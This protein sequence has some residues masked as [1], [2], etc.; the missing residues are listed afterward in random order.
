MA[1]WWEEEMADA[2]QQ[3]SQDPSM[4]L[5]IA[6]MPGSMVKPEIDP[7]LAGLLQTAKEATAREEKS[8]FME[9][10]KSFGSFASQAIDL[11]GSSLFGEKLWGGFRSTAEFLWTP[12]D[13]L[14]SS[15]YWMY[16]EV[17]S[18]PLTMAFLQASKVGV[19]G[20]FS[21]LT[22]TEEWGDAYK[23]AENI[24]PGQ[25]AANY[26]A[27]VGQAM[28]EQGVQGLGDAIGFAARN[29]LPGMGLSDDQ[30]RRGERLL[31]DTEY[32]RNKVG[33]KY[34]VGTGAA[35]FTIAVG[36]DPVY[37]IIKGVSKGVKY[38]R[39][40]EVAK[41]GMEP[42]K[43]QRSA[44]DAARSAQ[45]NEFYDFAADN[46]GK[47]MNIAAHPI[48]GKGRR[49]NTFAEAYSSVYANATRDEMP[50]ILRF[51]AGDPKAL[52]EIGRRNQALGLQLSRM[53][54]SR[55]FL[56]SGK[57]DEGVLAFMVSEEAAGRVAP[58]LPKVMGPGIGGTSP[59]SGMLNELIEPPYP[60]P[61]QPG[62]RQS[63]WDAT[64]GHLAAKGKALR[65][66]AGEVLTA[67]QGVLPTL[68]GTKGL[69][70]KDIKVAE[71]WR[72][73]KL[74]AVN[75]ELEALTKQQGVYQTLL[76][77]NF[78]KAI[79]D[80][81]PGSSN[82][83][84]AHRSL[85]RMGTYGGDV[86]KMGLKAVDRLSAGRGNVIKQQGGITSRVVRSGFYS[87][88]VRVFQTFGETL[89][90]TMINHTANDA[91]E[92]VLAM[93]KQVRGLDPALRVEM[94]NN[95]LSA[96]D[97]VARSRQLKTIHEAIIH[98]YG[99]ARGI[100]P[101]VSRIIA[102]M[103][104]NGMSATLN[105]LIG[106]TP[107]QQRFTAA[108][109]DETARF[110]DMVE[111]GE[112]LVV[113]PLAK[114]QLSQG[115][116]LLPVRDLER[117]IDR[118]AG[119]L[120]SFKQGMGNA[121]DFVIGSADGLSKVWKAATLLR[122]AY[123]VRS[124]SEEMAASVV[125]FGLLTRLGH[126]GE[127]GKHF[128]QNRG[129]QIQAFRGQASYIPTT[130]KGAA[131][132]LSRIAID[133]EEA[134][135][136]AAKYPELKAEKIK[137]PKQWAIVAERLQYETDRLSKM[138]T[139]LKNIYK[140]DAPARESTLDR[141]VGTADEL[142]A[143][144]ASSQAIVKEFSQYAEVLLRESTDATGKRLAEDMLEY[145]GVAFGEAFSP[146]WENPIAR[147]QITSAKAVDFLFSRGESIDLGRFIKTGDWQVVK[148]G[149]PNH[150][151]AWLNALNN[152]FRQDALFR[153]VAS[154]Q[155]MTAARKFLYSAEGK[156]HLRDLGPWADDID[157]LLNSIR[158]TLDQY[159]PR[160]TGLQSKLASGEH[161][162][163]AELRA[164]MQTEDFPMVHGEEL[165]A[166]ARVTARKSVSAQFDE[167]IRNGYMRL[168][169]I[170]S[171][172]L[173]RHP[174]F[175]ESYKIRMK[176]LIDNHI[177][178]RRE[179]GADESISTKELNTMYETATAKAKKDISQVVYDPSRTT[180]TEA[181]RFVAPFLSAHGDSLQRWAGLV[182]EK[183][184]FL[185]RVAQIY[186]APVAAN[187]ITDD[188]G[189]AVGQDGYATIELKV[190][191]P[192][193]GKTT[194]TKERKKVPLSERV[195][196]LRLPWDT[197]NK[198]RILGKVPF[199]GTRIKLQAMNTILPGDP[200]FHPGTGPLTQVPASAIAKL[201]PQTGEFLQWAKVIPYG[202]SG[203]WHE[204]FTPK[205]MKA[206]W[207]AFNTEDPDNEKYQQ[208]YLDVFNRH[209]AE[210]YEGKR[211]NIDLKK[212][213]QQAKQFMYLQAF[214]AWASPAQ[215]KDTPLT[216]TPY[217]FYVDQYR[218]M[219]AADPKNGAAQFQATHGSDYAHFAASLTKSIGVAPSISAMTTAE[220]HREMIERYPE[221]ASWIVGDVYNQ[222]SFS[223]S[224]YR[225]QMETMMG[226]K[227]MREKGSALD[228]IRS[229]E[230]AQGWQMYMQ[231]KGKMDAAL[232]SQGFRSYQDAGAEHLNALRQQAVDQ[233]SLMF[234]EWGKERG[235]VD[236]Q[237]TSNLIKFFTQAVQDPRLRSDPMRQDVPAMAQYLMIRQQFK[238]E[239]NAR[240]AKS[241]QFDVAGNPTG[242][243]ADLGY[244]WRVT[245]M[246]LVNSNT[247]FQDVFNRYLENDDLS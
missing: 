36:L 153:A 185:G 120:Q 173:V 186:N 203:E 21:Y 19:T 127:G 240:G 6:T 64:Y 168:S 107:N 175:N 150:M 87:T 184:E 217:Q 119:R 65:G 26:G 125:K 76:G 68:F 109:G 211:E 62:P 110:A 75:A 56:D 130:G 239:L 81:S 90:D 230:I 102:G 187:L 219:V 122:P 83:F 97:K 54:E 214:E 139:Q 85:Y 210:V 171:D 162:T 224:V 37:P 190:T 86:E 183:P 147:D 200:W 177:A 223:S 226:G 100:D 74:E 38:A 91:G 201:S 199:Y 40:I 7:K 98:H 180:A 61:T 166:L 18:Q 154:D 198:S 158:N 112:G 35:D 104:D 50:L 5:Q 69:R 39:N 244:S 45:V 82:L 20:D 220:E 29:P 48:W 135:A 197:R 3:M 169:G 188:Q 247:Q 167:L 189:N 208:A 142:E 194:T 106:K 115:E 41:P 52:V 159:V 207:D 55:A 113:A 246:G 118:H 156:A 111:D 27:T 114:T 144:I 80:F 145:R 34:T 53:N 60:R 15:A 10:L 66:A 63:G 32:W 67:R 14:A 116:M 105:K 160:G 99:R 134:R 155:S 221:M 11:G 225:K 229:N 165:T 205:Y 157:G 78:G 42:T 129:T 9:K 28:N 77:E 191:D 235:K 172:L 195:I 133:D 241:L 128:F 228:A 58:S 4:A 57:F 44:E 216:G 24:S 73:A 22:D 193:T 46:A 25:A 242:T 209:K 163:E 96:T 93:L 70:A 222:G 204:A 141:W 234:P 47:A 43:F 8:G 236:T 149:D 23:R 174:V 233:L 206:A 243:N 49:K 179:V 213:E 148:P 231:A 176:E 1:K 237:K 192:V 245:Q 232:I 103:V 17:V 146:V 170:P 16:S 108:A 79:D 161:V 31:Y 95:Y 137:M 2:S 132:R 218:K 94:A 131:S 151:D 33:W 123:T 30:K 238:A 89:P 178:Y 126:F 84:G 88:P 101:E 124:V 196:N 227:P 164:A 92:R 140:K 215:T 59:E 71:T 136:I 51:Q 182:G 121:S 12:V 138:E 143:E 212:V 152:Q 72:V 181:L 117:F 13:K 202:P